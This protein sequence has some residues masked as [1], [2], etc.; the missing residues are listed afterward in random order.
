MSKSLPYEQWLD[1]ELQL[2]EA[3]SGPFVLDLVAGCGGLALGFEA[4]GF[5]TIGFEMDADCCATYR[6][7]LHSPC[8][9]MTLRAGAELSDG[10]QVIIGG[11]PCQP[12]S[13]NGHQQG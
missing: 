13:V 10:A 5:L 9:Q 11:P 3:K 8:H 6:A 2:P 1:R 12:F 7:N 4:A